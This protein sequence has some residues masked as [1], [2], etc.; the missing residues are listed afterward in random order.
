MP[1]LMLQYRA[2]AFFARLYAPETTMGLMTS[3]EM[4]DI[5]E[6]K[7]PSLNEVFQAPPQSNV[8]DIS[9]MQ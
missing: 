4:R 6:Q 3:E 7:K 2:G 1:E 8:V 9:E 5:Q